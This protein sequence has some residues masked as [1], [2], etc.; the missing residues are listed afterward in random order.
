MSESWL[1]YYILL[2]QPN[3]CMKLHICDV[4]YTLTLLNQS[5]IFE[6]SSLFWKCPSSCYQNDVSSPYLLLWN[7][8]LHNTINIGGPFSR[9]QLAAPA[10]HLEERKGHTYVHTYLPKAWL[11][12]C[13]FSKRFYNFFNFFCK[14]TN[15]NLYM[16]L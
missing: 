14:H 2:K 7:L 12:T 9:K 1:L 5:A 16:Q 13:D 10:R 4:L 6:Y 11:V 8:S 15:P 3:K